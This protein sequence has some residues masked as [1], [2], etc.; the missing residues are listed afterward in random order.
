MSAASRVSS[1]QVIDA[2]RLRYPTPEWAFLEQVR[3]RTGYDAA[4]PRYAD[5]LAMNLYASRG[6]ELHGIEVK[7]DRR[8][9]LREARDPDKAEAIARYCHRW[10]IAAPPRV[11]LLDELPEGWGLFAYE[12]GKLKVARPAPPREPVPPS[13]PFVGA[14]LRNAQ[15][16]LDAPIDAAVQ[17]VRA[18]LGKAHQ[19]ELDRVE[20]RRRDDR[21][22]LD[23]LTRACGVLSLSEH[24]QVLIERIGLI[25]RTYLRGE[26]L[27]E[28]V[29]MALRQV[30]DIERRLRETLDAL[31]APRPQPAE[32]RTPA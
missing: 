27:E 13:L 22:V 21:R 15:R 8:D 29:R 26:N 11:V 28:P 32:E 7:V 24:D 9:W 6:M 5:V 4:S 31:Q 12:D 1:A 23:A 17:R 16:E 3:N 25:V 20:R 2:L 18:E 30:E 19:A 10:W 14:I